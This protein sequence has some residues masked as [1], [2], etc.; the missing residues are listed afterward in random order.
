[1]PYGLGLL[2]HE[3]PKNEDRTDVESKDGRPT[4]LLERTA[5]SV[6]AR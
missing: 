2:E 5:S 3:E 4:F 6:L 1:M